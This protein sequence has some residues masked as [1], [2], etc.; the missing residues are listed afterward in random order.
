M[1][2]YTVAKRRDHVQRS[3]NDARYCGDGLSW[4]LIRIMDWET[5]G[6]L[7]WLYAQ[8]TFY[9]GTKDIAN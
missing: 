1:Q 9:V 7:N 5:L 3:I 4:G 6:H 8:E 2:I